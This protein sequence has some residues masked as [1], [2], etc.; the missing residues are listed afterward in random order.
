[1]RESVSHRQIHKLTFGQKRD[2]PFALIRLFRIKI[3]MEITPGFSAVL[4]ERS[5]GKTVR[6]QPLV[7]G[8]RGGTMTPLSC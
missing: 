5:D 7:N 8:F 2:R 3:S 1:M 4:E 6:Q